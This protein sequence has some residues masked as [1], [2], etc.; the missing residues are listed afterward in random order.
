MSAVQQGTRTVFQPSGRALIEHLNS[1]VTKKDLGALAMLRRGLGHQPSKASENYAHILPF[2]S[3]PDSLSPA[4][5]SREEDAALVIAPL[6]AQWHQ[7]KAI[8]STAERVGLGIAFRQL[9]NQS[10]SGSI[11]QRFVALL[12][13]SRDQLPNHL[14]HAVSLLKAKDIPLDWALLFTDLYQWDQTDRRARH[15]VRR[16]WARDFW[17][18]SR[19]QEGAAGAGSRDDDANG[20]NDE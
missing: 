5:R 3:P 9:M 12:K 10:D 14:R 16:R 2:L 4:Q 17:E 15:P 1:L 8:P 18:R 11:E 13:A 6:Y 19:P 7:G 20:D